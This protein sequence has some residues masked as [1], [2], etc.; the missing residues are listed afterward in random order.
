MNYNLVN[1]VG[2]YATGFF[3]PRVREI[4]FYISTYDDTRIIDRMLIP[5]CFNKFFKDIS[6]YS[7]C[8]SKKEMDFGLKRHDLAT[9]DGF[10]TNFLLTIA[11]LD[12]R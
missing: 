10:I 12:D 1:P 8:T 3:V 7:Y 11:N 4:Y 5:I 2:I 6:I 9:T